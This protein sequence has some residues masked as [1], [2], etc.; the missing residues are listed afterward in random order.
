MSTRRPPVSAASSSSPA[1]RRFTAQPFRPPAV[2]LMAVDPYFSI[3]SCTDKLTDE[4]TRHWTN[5]HHDLRGLLRIDGRVY[6][7][8]GG[9]IEELPALEQV[10]VVV[11]PTRTVYTFRSP[12][13]ELVLTFLTPMLP[14]DLDVFSWP[15]TYVEFAISSRDGRAHDTAIYF[16]LAGRITTD[17]ERADVTWFRQQQAESEIIGC[18]TFDQRVLTRTGD[19]VRI[20]WGYLYLALPKAMGGQAV[21]RCHHE[22]RTAFVQGK[23]FPTEDATNYPCPYF[24]FWPSLSAEIPVRVKPGTVE[25]RYIVAAYD[26]IYSLE[27]FGRKLRPYWRRGDADAGSL[28]KEAVRRHDEIK[29]RCEQLDRR[30][31][32]ELDRA[33]GPEFARLASLAYRQ[34]CAAHK[35]AADFDGSF[36]YFS[37]ENFSNGSINTVD[38]TYPSAPFFLLFQ[39]A[40]LQAQI[41]PIFDYARS[42]RWKFP[43]APHD[44]GTYPRANGQTYGG[45][46]TSERDQMPVEEC[47]NMILLAAALVR[48]QTD[49]AFVEKNWDLLTQWARYLDA[50]GFDP[51]MQLCT[52]DFA[53]HLAH[54]ANLSIKAIL[55]LGAYAQLATATGRAALAKK[56]RRRAEAMVKQWLKAADDGDHY[57]LCFDGPK[58]WSLKYNLFWDRALKLHLFPKQV[59]A[60]EQAH[61]RRMELRFGMPL[62]NR[63]TYGKIDWTAWWAA[64]SE[65]EDEFRAFIRPLHAWCHETESRVPMTDWYYADS[66]LMAWFR[67]RSVV[68][69]IFAK[70]YLDRATGKK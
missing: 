60:K 28:L 56:Y 55:A 15:V 42:G 54:N 19:D 12:E 66:G 64:L 1:L 70:L 35:L 11:F 62:D 41:G 13:V 20:D 50:R 31:V 16:D 22:A 24:N 38:V 17:D 18:G 53:G 65:N 43:F 4:G 52:D 3:W 68:G 63:K 61:Y 57:R 9:P 47:G 27:Y 14:E 69:G 58:T 48:E 25:T 40:L 8:I 30:V 26:D 36:V 10:S 32:T 46:E 5:H 21:T 51:E 37:K 2:P 45:G 59:F 67:A 39:P 6:R 34:T 29:R 23:P 49:A 7:F 33:G 44:L